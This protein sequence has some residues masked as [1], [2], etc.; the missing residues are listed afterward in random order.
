MK[1]IS[2]LANIENNEEKKNEDQFFLTQG[3]NSNEVNA[4]GVTKTHNEKDENDNVGN[5]LEFY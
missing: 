3:N 1:R 2:K 5:L 4:I